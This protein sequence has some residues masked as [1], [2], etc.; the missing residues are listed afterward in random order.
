MGERDEAHPQ[1]LECLKFGHLRR[2]G[3]EL[4][5]DQLR[6]GQR[7]RAVARQRLTK[8]FFMAVKR[9]ISG[10]IIRKGLQHNC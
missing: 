9:L 4:R 10:G 8:S 3:S 7:G 2:H 5:V 6:R 1:L